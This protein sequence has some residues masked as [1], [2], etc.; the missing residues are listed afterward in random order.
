[1]TVIKARRDW[2]TG[3]SKILTIRDRGDLP[4]AEHL[5]AGIRNTKSIRTCYEE[6]R[7]NG[8]INCGARISLIA[9][10]PRALDRREL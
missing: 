1:V 9:R 7:S 5:S 10:W 8:R 3:E 2:L 4:E 6:W